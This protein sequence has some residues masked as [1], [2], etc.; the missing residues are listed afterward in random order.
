MAGSERSTIR[1][2]TALS[3][4]LDVH[5]LVVDERFVDAALD[6]ERW[7]PH[8]LPHWVGWDRS[9]ARYRLT[10]RGLELSIEADQRAWCPP[11]TGS[12]R[13]SS[14]QTGSFSG[15]V[16][17]TI[18][19]HRTSDRLTVVET[20]P[21]RQLLTPTYGAVELRGS[22]T[23]HADG[24]VAFWMIGVEDRPEHSGEICVC[25]IFGSEAQPGSALVGCGV[26]PF[27]DPSL[28]D[29]FRKVRAEIDVSTIHDYAAVWTMD[30]VTFFIDGE[31]VH[32]VAP[33]PLGPHAAHDR[34]LRLR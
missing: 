12:M 24:M 20:V 31:L 14:L 11:V 26:R 7:I 4:L 13:V 2:V 30:D 17:S 1:S 32:R 16:D 27:G 22:W 23:P 25:E 28:H 19:Q 18:G 8:Y 6:P 15:P 29:R 5:R 10:D 3:E 9:A 21:Y 33:A 34:Y